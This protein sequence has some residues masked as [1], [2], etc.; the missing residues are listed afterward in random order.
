MR[1]WLHEIGHGS[2]PCDI[3]VV[4]FYTSNGGAGGEGMKFF[5]ILGKIREINKMRLIFNLNKR[6]T[7]K[8]N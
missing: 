1:S 7:C 5:D 4:L 2:N 8:Y 3:R 6:L